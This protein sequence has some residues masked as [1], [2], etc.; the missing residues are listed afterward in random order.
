MTAFTELARPRARTTLDTATLLVRFGLAPR[1]VAH[2]TQ[3]D[4]G[5]LVAVW[6]QDIVPCRPSI[7]RKPDHGGS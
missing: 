6:C 5:R 2:W 3:D 1:L 7:A 4:T